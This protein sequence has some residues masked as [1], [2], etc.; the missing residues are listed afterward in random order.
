[1]IRRT[2]E[3]KREYYNTDNGLIKSQLGFRELR[4]FGILI[5]KNKF[6]F[7]SETDRADKETVLGFKS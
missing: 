1:M 2:W 4:I 5:F 7:D 3:E 6:H